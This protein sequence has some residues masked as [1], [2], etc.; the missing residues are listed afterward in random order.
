[1]K[2]E[3]RHFRI[4][5]ALG[6]LLPTLPWATGNLTCP[7]QSGGWS[8]LDSVLPTIQK[9]TNLFFQCICDCK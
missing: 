6:P 4:V 1:M 9:L 8:S 3:S 7:M 5:V 2:T